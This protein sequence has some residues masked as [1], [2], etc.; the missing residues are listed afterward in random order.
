MGLEEVLVS[1]LME[2]RLKDELD[3]MGDN[4]GAAAD[5]GFDEEA[6]KEASEL[7][8][9]SAVVQRLF[10]PTAGIINISK[11]TSDERGPHSVEITEIF[12]HVIEKIFREINSLVI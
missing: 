6:A 11:I 9:E 10:L 4:L 8:L 5:E 7:V 1:K 3:G 2:G 12:C